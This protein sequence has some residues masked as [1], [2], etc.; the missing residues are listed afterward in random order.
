MHRYPS[1]TMRASM[2]SLFIV[3]GII[4]VVASILYVGEIVDNLT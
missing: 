2:T 3:T 4:V 1:K